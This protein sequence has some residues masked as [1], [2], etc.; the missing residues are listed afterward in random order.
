M[1]QC[2]LQGN[3]WNLGIEGGPTDVSSYASVDYDELMKSIDHLGEVK[4]YDSLVK[5]SNKQ[6]NQISKSYNLLLDFYHWYGELP[7][8]DEKIDNEV[9]SRIESILE[10]L[11]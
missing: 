7:S 1:Q 10:V 11:K 8:T 3:V 2:D 6:F 4:S 5:L 9:L